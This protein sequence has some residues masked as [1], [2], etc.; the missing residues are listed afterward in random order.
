MKNYLAG[1]VHTHRWISGHKKLAAVALSGA[2][3]IGIGGVAA[4]Y[5][6]TTAAGSGTGT[7]G[8]SKV[9]TIT[10]SSIVYSNAGSDNAL[11]PGTSAA[12]TLAANN[13]SSGNQYL[14]TISL[15]SWTSTVTG[16]NSVADPGWFTMVPVV[17]NADE[18]AGAHAAVG[19]GTIL[20]NDLAVS[21]NICQGAT[22]TFN[23]TA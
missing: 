22:F 15:A 13:I 7:G 10:Q 14:G 23:Y 8:S 4:A 11:L 16:C 12:V 18:S 17:V 1:S 20:E 19:V 9:I 2:L 6:T 3:L 21:Q 5:I